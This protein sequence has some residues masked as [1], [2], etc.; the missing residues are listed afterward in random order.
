M[1]TIVSKRFV[2][3]GYAAM[4]VWPFVF[5]REKRLVTASRLNHERIH[6]RQQ[7]ELLVLPFFIW[8]AVDFLIKYAKYRNWKQA[9]R[10]IIFEKEAY[11]NGDDLS[12]LKSRKTWG[13]MR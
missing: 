4:A 9:Y 11:A 13:F 6:L 2:P 12:Y 8:Y 3:K 10:N 5:F 7:I 1:W